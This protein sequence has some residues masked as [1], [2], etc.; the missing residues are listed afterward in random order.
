MAR[1]QELF[2]VKLTKLF[3]LLKRSLPLEP[4]RVSQEILDK[5]SEVAHHLKLL[6]RRGLLIAIALDPHLDRG[7]TVAFL[8]DA[9]KATQTNAPSFFQL[10]ID[11]NAHTDDAYLSSLSSRVDICKLCKKAVAIKPGQGCILNGSRSICHIECL[12]CPSCNGTP[13]CMFDLE[14]QPFVECS[15]CDHGGMMD[16]ILEQSGGP[17]LLL[18]ST[19]LV[20]VH[21]LYVSW[22]RM[23]RSLMPSFDQCMPPHPR[24]IGTLTNP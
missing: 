22:S 17:F 18:K 24:E 12:K 8:A 11:R 9:A 16:F 2:C 23:A 10:I 1:E 13:R 5:V 20:S 19:S 7:I 6:V 15:E 3:S 21:Q 4:H 14:G